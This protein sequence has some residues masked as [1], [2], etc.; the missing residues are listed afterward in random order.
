MAQQRRVGAE[1]SETRAA[2]LDSTERLML[3]EGYAAVTYRRVAAAAGVTAPLVQYYFPTLDDLFLALLRRRSDRNLQKLKD[4]LETHPD[5]PLR[6]IWEYSADETSS[7]LLIE[8][9]ALGN[10][11]KTIRAEIAE[12]SERS[13]KVQLDALAATRKS[14]AGSNGDIPDA[15]LLFLMAGIP[16]VMLMESDLG[17]STGHTE[18]LDLIT[19]YLNWTEPSKPSK[20]PRKAAK[21]RAPAKR[22]TASSSRGKKQTPATRRAPARSKS[23]PS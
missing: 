22:A 23:A 7:A 12:T 1:T 15:A 11:R 16:K 14:R 18:T 10:H 3:D 6:V 9:M 5:A 21:K 2:L 19:R 17:V 8:F 20:Q 13:R 4:S